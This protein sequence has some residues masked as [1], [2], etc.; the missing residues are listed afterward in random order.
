M[1]YFYSPAKYNWVALS[2]NIEER[3]NYIKQII[4]SHIYD[5]S[6]D[7]WNK[8]CIQKLT[9]WVFSQ[10]PLQKRGLKIS[11]QINHITTT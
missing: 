9:I 2:T 10:S 3:K 8:T 4:K 11:L 6:K 7:T 5:K 1:L